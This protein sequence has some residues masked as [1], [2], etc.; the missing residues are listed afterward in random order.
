MSSKKF[1]IEG[2]TVLMHC[3]WSP[4]STPAGAALAAGESVPTAVAYVAVAT[5][6]LI[7]KLSRL[8]ILAKRRII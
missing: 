2:E 5:N 6:E 1:G 7:T 3:L 8:N 4:K